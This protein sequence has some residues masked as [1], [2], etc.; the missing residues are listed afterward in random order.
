LTVSIVQNTK[1]HCMN[2]IKIPVMLYLVVYLA[3]TELRGLKPADHGD[4]DWT[5]LAKVLHLRVS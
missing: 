2:K 1:T 4:V 3:T 5:Y